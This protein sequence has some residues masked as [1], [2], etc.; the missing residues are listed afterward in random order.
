[1]KPG[2]RLRAVEK[3]MGLKKGE[4]VQAIGVIEVVSVREEPLGAIEQ[5]DCVAE[6]FPD[7][8][9]AEFVAMYRSFAGGPA[10]QLVTRIEFKH[11]DGGA[12]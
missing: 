11:V 10:D 8:S 7:L 12:F 1:M 2:D 3:A 5:A 6:G 4:K 9:P